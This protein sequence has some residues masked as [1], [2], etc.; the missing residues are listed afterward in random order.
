[1]YC[2][3]ILS[4]TRQIYLFGGCV[5]NQWSIFSELFCA[6]INGPSIE[7]DALQ[8]PLV[9][10]LE[11]SQEKI[12]LPTSN[13]RNAIN[14]MKSEKE[15]SMP[16]PWVGTLATDKYHLILPSFLQATMQMHPLII[17][18]DRTQ[19]A[20]NK[21]Q[22]LISIW[23]TKDKEHNGPT[24]KIMNMQ[25]KFPTDAKWTNNETVTSNSHLIHRIYFQVESHFAPLAI[26]SFHSLI[27]LISVLCVFS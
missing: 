17:A 14:F 27:V 21:C 20:G 22:H 11:R 18:A 2:I 25:M 5:P 24:Q 3:I 7:H 1:M 6:I 15:K 12:W 13:D 8:I 19:A 26:H 10:R 9:V 4:S 16:L 23:T